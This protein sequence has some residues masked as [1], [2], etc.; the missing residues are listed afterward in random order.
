MDANPCPEDM[1]YHLT[2]DLPGIIVM[3]DPDSGWQLA[4][5]LNSQLGSTP[6]VNHALPKRASGIGSLV[7]FHEFGIA[8]F[9]VNTCGGNRDSWPYEDVMFRW[10]LSMAENLLQNG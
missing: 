3:S 1:A 6:L 2:E 5:A 7:T 4:Q 8:E 9:I 10:V